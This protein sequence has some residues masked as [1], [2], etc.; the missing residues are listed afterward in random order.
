[1]KEKKRIRTKSRVGSIVKAKVGEMEDNKRK[2]GIRSMI[3]EVVG[4]VQAVAG[5][6]KFLVQFEDSQ[7]K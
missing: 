6:N 1:M 4:C 2:A 7:K 5:N 3:K